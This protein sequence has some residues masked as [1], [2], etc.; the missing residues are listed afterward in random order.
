MTVSEAATASH[1][2]SFATRLDLV[3]GGLLK[4]TI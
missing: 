4:L 1:R 2:Q 3:S